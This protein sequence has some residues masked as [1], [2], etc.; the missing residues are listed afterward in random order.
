MARV[1]YLTYDGL[2]DQ[3]GQSQIIPYIK[4]LS[5]RGHRFTV[6]SFEK[7]GNQ[8][9]I[10]NTKQELFK[11]DITWRPLTYTKRP[12]IL[13][14]I[15][16]VQRL[17]YHA[18]SVVRGNSIEIIHCRSYI[19]SLVGLSLKKSRKLKFIFDMRDFWADERVDGGLWNL[20]NPVYH[21]VYRFFKKK[22]KQFWYHSDHVITLT[23]KAKE[24]IGYHKEITRISVIPTSVDIGHFKNPDLS[25]KSKFQHLN[26]SK[27]DF[28]VSYVGSLGSW[29]KTKELLRLF[30]YIVAKNPK[31]KLLV[32]TK[33][34]VNGLFDEAKSQNIPLEKITVTQG[35]RD[36]MPYLISYSNWSVFFYSP[37]AAKAGTSPTKMAELV[38][39]K[40]PI[41]ANEGVGDLNML[42]D[43]YS[44]GIL[45]KDINDDRELEQASKF[46]FGNPH[47]R[48]DD[49]M[50]YDLFDLN[51]ACEKLNDIYRQL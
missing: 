42:F 21:L 43:K 35:N 1:L 10:E 51:V 14:T 32:V 15:L 38:S 37:S 47:Y 6:I 49:K 20:K 46:I 36:E 24:L 50:V 44:L 27:N 31:S 26:L 5:K 2:T 3:L 11:M 40:I 13:S 39:Q 23:E 17:K 9:S 4:G 28:I 25:L 33:S 29:Y 45:V 18:L 19:T 30:G 8:K 22:E 48:S 7:K 12:P 41:V 34:P 16:D